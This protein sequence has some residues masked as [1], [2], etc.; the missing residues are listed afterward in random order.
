MHKW[1]NMPYVA[2]WIGFWLCACVFVW[3]EC[4]APE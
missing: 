4:G 1:D 2:F 3:R